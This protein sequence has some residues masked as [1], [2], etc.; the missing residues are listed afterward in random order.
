MSII[1]CSNL[2]SGST[3][4]D[5]S[6]V[7]TANHLSQCGYQLSVLNFVGPGDGSKYILPRWPLDRGIKVYPIQV[8]PANGGRNLH[9]GFHPVIKGRIPNLSYSFTQNSLLALR[10][11]NAALKK[12]DVII[13]SH[14]LQAEIFGR[15]IVG[16]KRR[17][18][19]IMQIHGDYKVR[20]PELGP[21]LTNARPVVDEVQIV[22][23]GMA[24]DYSDEF[25][26]EKVTWVPNLHEPSV[27]SRRPHGGVN[28]VLVGS[29]QDAKNQLDAVRMLERVTDRS[30]RLTLWGNDQN[31][32]GRYVRSV[33]A[34]HGLV[35][36]VD[37]A[38]IGD[39]HSIYGDADIVIIPSLSEGFGY[40]LVEAAAHGLPVVA[41]DYNYG[42]RDVIEDG[43][44]GFIVPLGDVDALASRVEQLAEDE[45]LRTR[46]GTRARQVFEAEFAPAPVMARYVSLLDGVARG[47]TDIGGIF[48]TDGLDPVIGSSI[49]WRPVQLFRRNVV[50]VVGFRS[51]QGLRRFRID[52]GRRTRRAVVLR[53]RGRYVVAVLRGRGWRFW[54]ARQ[55]VVSYETTR[56]QDGRYYL[57]NSTRKGR[58]EVARFLRRDGEGATGQGS[59]LDPANSPSPAFAV[60]DGSLALPRHPRFPAVSGEDSFGAPLNS[61]GGVAL[62]N[63]G[64]VRDPRVSLR[65]EFDAVTYFDAEAVHTFKPP[66]GYGELFER[67]CAAERGG[68]LFDVTT[69]GEDIHVWELYRAAFIATLSECL[70]LWGSHFSIGGSPTWDAYAGPKR[71]ADGRGFR[72]VLFEFPRKPD[73][74]DHRTEAFHDSDTM[75]IE[76]PQEYGYSA[77]V[78]SA[79]NV[80][81]IREFNL[82]RSKSQDRSSPPVDIRPIEAALGD[83]LGFPVR[84]GN[85]I[86]RRV[87]KFVDE[88]D[89]WLPIFEHIKPDEVILPSSHWSAGICDAAR[90]AGSEVSDIQYA[91]TS[92]KHPS[93]WFGD[94]PRHGASKFYAWSSFW[95][96][97]TNVYE[98]CEEFSRP[99][100]PGLA[101]EPAPSSEFD[102]CLVSQPRV[103]RRMLHFLEGLVDARPD[104]R[105]C[106][107]P[108]PDER[109]AFSAKLAQFGHPDRLEI[110]R[111][112]TLDAVKQSAV[113][114]G[115][116]STSMYEAVSLG[117]PTYVLPVPGHEIVSNEI[118]S[119]M[120]RPFSGYAEL[121]PYDVPDERAEIF[122]G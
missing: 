102:F 58:F 113:C 50:H 33:V 27:A 98:H 104:A 86:Q 56:P 47:G 87:D 70:G 36:R 110:A 40:A 51:T 62:V 105:I 80:Y 20:H 60:V 28:V 38:G 37:F 52:D 97:R 100:T 108:H 42:P 15:A 95:R 96:E 55:K 32:Y 46:L 10:Q 54:R 90:L 6:L 109:N 16:D 88:R 116:Y 25:G 65:G 35:N 93:Y 81:P 120:F 118:D 91:L 107:A 4:L 103:L 13:F 89:F 7:M 77:A 30:V 101:N 8:L 39:E 19:T 61:P 117:V 114:I 24:H 43:C 59:V 111:T 75:V 73:G 34:R 57:G 79:D 83:A 22:S 122:G 121:V 1:L 67:V 84:L 82:W 11:I 53:L 99:V 18:R 66:Y 23:Q 49:V 3:G 69:E 31:N 5:K 64:D 48:G 21:M 26:P 12:S 74:L 119:G 68:A 9:D 44:S 29:F 92:P 85:A 17:A 72:R 78:Y 41:Y 71:L 106:V 112:S 45:A 94:T 76:Y 14:P 2:L 115:G 63:S